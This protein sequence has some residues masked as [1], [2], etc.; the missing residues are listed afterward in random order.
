VT[1]TEE[2]AARLVATPASSY[3]ELSQRPEVRA[4][5]QAAIDGLN[6]HLPSYSTIKKFEVLPADFTQATGELTPSLKVKRKFC[7]Q[8]YKDV[9]DRLYGPD[10]A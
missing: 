3:A 1:V 8:K 9:L 10:A 4:A 6:A 2:A 5:V 7:N